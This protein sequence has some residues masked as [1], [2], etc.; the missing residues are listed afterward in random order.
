MNEAVVVIFNTPTLSSTWYSIGPIGN[1]CKI[2]IILYYILPWTHINLRPTGVMTATCFLHV[3]R[4]VLNVQQRG[5][6]IE[7]RWYSFM[8]NTCSLSV[9]VLVKQL[10]G[11]ISIL[12]FDVN[13]WYLLVYVSTSSLEYIYYYCWHVKFS[14]VIPLS[15]SHLD[16]LA[17]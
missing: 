6:F 17:L 2:Y 7:W 10:I 5:R 9:A 3:T 4:Y 1:T 8:S 16:I 14:L 15:D 13:W 12:M 11:S